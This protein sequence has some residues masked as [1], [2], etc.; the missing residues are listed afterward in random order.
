MQGSCLNLLFSTCLSIWMKIL[1]FRSEVGQQNY[2]GL[3]DI[4]G[5]Y[6]CQYHATHM[7]FSCHPWSSCG[8]HQQPQS[9]SKHMEVSWNRGTP[10]SST[11]NGIFHYKRAI[12]E[13][14]IETSISRSSFISAMVTNT[15]PRLTLFRILPGHWLNHR[16]KSCCISATLWTML[17]MIW[18]SSCQLSP[19]GNTQTQLNSWQIRAVPLDG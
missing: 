7:F 16:L 17:A 4:R 15:C 12:Y 10:K 5:V 11:L 9:L 8:M 13:V 19:Q 2:A 18:Y 3:N 6:S 14:I 1:K